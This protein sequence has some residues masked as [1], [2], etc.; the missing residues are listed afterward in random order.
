MKIAEIKE[1]IYDIRY[2]ALLSSFVFISGVLAGYSF[3]SDFP[4]ETQ[5]IVEKL[6]EFFAS[7][8]EMTQFQIFLFILENNIIKLFAILLLGIFAGII[9]LFASFTNGMVLG[10]FACLVS[11]SLSWKFFLVGILPHGIIEIP[12]LILATAVGIRLGKIT[13]WRLFG[14]KIGIKKELAKALKFYIIVLAPLLVIAAMIEAFI[15][16]AMLDRI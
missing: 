2:Y 4:E 14:G 1:Y 5:E 7:G 16:P 8:K 15:T 3:V 11:E 6:K 13:L 10:I 9:P 12:V